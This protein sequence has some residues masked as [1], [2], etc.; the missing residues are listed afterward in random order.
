MF[1]I[2][3]VLAKIP[4]K[5]MSWITISAC[6]SATYFCFRA[7]YCKNSGVTTN[8]RMLRAW[9]GPWRSST[10]VQGWELGFDDLCLSLQTQDILWF[11]D[12]MVLW[13]CE[14]CILVVTYKSSKPPNRKSTGFFISHHVKESPHL[15]NSLSAR[16]ATKFS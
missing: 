14:F 9:N 7:L 10:P 13:Y 4:V 16:L 1:W 5:S 12:C 8:H 6:V 15:C 3:T 11:C 2:C